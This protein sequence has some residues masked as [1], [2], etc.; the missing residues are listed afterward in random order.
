[1]SPQGPEGLS[2]RPLKNPRGKRGGA[3]ARPPAGGVR[4]MR[5]PSQRGRR[6]RGDRRR[7]EFRPTPSAR[8]RSWRPTASATC[9]LRRGEPRRRNVGIAHARGGIVALTDDDCTT[10]RD[11]I[12]EL[13]D[14]FAVDEAV[15]PG[16]VAGPMK[17]QVQVARPNEECVSL[18]AQRPRRMSRGKQRVE[19]RFTALSSSA[20]CVSPQTAAVAQMGVRCC[21][22]PDPAR[23]EGCP[24]TDPC[25]G[26]NA[27]APRDPAVGE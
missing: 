14:A 15:R 7:P 12:C 4:T 16:T 23:P 27:C 2:G 1:M 8:L 10:P 20:K 22:R 5:A 11:W 13:V 25:G 24:P 18:F 6:L 26:R 19:R 3:D 21:G 9:A 17:R